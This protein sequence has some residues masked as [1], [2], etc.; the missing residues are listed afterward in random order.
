MIDPVLTDFPI[1]RTKYFLSYPNDGSQIGLLMYKG[2]E[3]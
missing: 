1:L 3:A 2:W